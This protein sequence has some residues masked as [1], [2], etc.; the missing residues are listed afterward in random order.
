MEF[1]PVTVRDSVRSQKAIL[2]SLGVNHIRFAMGGSL[3]GMLTLEWGLEYGDTVDSLVVMACGAR[4]TAW[5]IAIN[6]TQRQAIFR[7]PNWEDGKGKAYGGLGLARQIA[8]VSYRSHA[9]YNKK[10]G[11]KLTKEMEAE[12]GDADSAILNGKVPHYNVEGYLAYQDHKFLSRFDAASYVRC[13]GT[14]DSH[15]VGRSRGGIESALKSLKMPTLVIGFDS[16]NLYPVSEQKELAALIPDSEL[17]ILSS[18]AGHDAFLLEYEAT[19][20]ACWEFFDK[21][22]PNQI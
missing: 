2:D 12:Y 21:H 5:Q 3:G 8:M 16:D 11:R 18:D 10:F 15:D 7:D 20:K 17:A 13:M 1:P 4:E 22:H 19:Q 14:L 6:E 9:A